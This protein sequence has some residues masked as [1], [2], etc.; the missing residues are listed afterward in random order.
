MTN[1]EVRRRAGV[2]ETLSE[3]VRRRRWAFLGHTLRRG[4]DDL[5]K[6]ALTWTPVGRRKRGRPKETFRR[7]VEK[8]RDQLGL[9]SWG[10]AANRAQDRDAWKS[11]I[12]G[13]MIHSGQR[14]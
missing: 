9:Q 7:T 11:L 2:A 6:T 13:A 10:A 5:A 14:S 1:E 3:I 8:E 4:P 12:A